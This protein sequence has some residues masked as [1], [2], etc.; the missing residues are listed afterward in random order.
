MSC[1]IHSMQEITKVATICNKPT[2]QGVRTLLDRV[3][4]WTGKTGLVSD[5]LDWSKARP[6]RLVHAAE[7]ERRCA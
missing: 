7:L 3:P 2:G 1:R 6:N 5:W 4:S